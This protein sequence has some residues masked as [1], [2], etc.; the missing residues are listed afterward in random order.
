V[1]VNT[2]ASNYR[3]HDASCRRGCGG[4]KGAA[5]G[6]GVT[7]YMC[8]NL[9][10]I[11]IG[12]PQCPFGF[13]MSLISSQLNLTDS[14]IHHQS[15]SHSSFFCIARRH[16]PIFLHLSSAAKQTPT[17]CFSRR[18]RLC[19]THS[20]STSDH[21]PGV[22]SPRHHVPPRL[23]TSYSRLLAA[24]RARTFPLRN[25]IIS[26]NPPPCQPPPRRHRQTD[27]PAA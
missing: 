21:K 27:S 6:R 3:S 14:S 11:I 17:P 12:C 25:G 9:A 16:K 8:I 26:P 1:V 13:S 23:S 15:A 10:H 2:P 4:F 19:A 22:F 20:S 24:W 5:N 7:D 18:L